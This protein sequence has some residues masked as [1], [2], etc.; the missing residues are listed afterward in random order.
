MPVLN[1]A[2]NS[3]DKRF[4]PIVLSIL[5]ELEKKG[6]QPIVAEGRRT[7]EQQREK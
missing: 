2:Y 1:A 5:E 3:L 4:Q 6:W 7:I